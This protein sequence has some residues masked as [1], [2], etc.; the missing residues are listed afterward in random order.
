MEN[1]IKEIIENFNLRNFDELQKHFYSIE[2]V[3]TKRFG[4]DKRQT[5]EIYF[6]G[7]YSDYLKDFCR[8]ET[9]SHSFNEK[10]FYTVKT[11]DI[12]ITVAKKR[13]KDESI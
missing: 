12:S 3:E 2:I 1:K 9:I 7:E 10:V 13:I 4:I 5:T 8:E 6:Q 11:G